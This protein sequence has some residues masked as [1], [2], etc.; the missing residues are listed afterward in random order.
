[1]FTFFILITALAARVVDAQMPENQFTAAEQSE[2]FTFDEGGETEINKAIEVLNMGT[3]DEVLIQ[4]VKRLEMIVS[5]EDQGSLLEDKID[6]HLN[7]QEEK[8]ALAEYEKEINPSIAI[9]DPQLSGL[10]GLMG[11]V[12]TGLGGMM[13]MGGSLLA[14][15]GNLLGLG[16]G[17]MEPGS[18]TSD[19]DYIYQVKIAYDQHLHDID[20]I[21]D[22]MIYC[23]C[24]LKRCHVS[25]NVTDGLNIYF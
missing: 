12:G 9:P 25:K 19:R 3:R 17:G 15:V 2:L 6:E 23:S 8:D 5:I 18:S 4:L 10:N 20:C 24:A 1:M 7:E 11:A 14:G 21:S 22:S 16:V 13:N